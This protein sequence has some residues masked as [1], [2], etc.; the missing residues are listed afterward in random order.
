MIKRPGQKI[1]RQGLIHL[2]VNNGSPTDP[3]HLCDDCKYE[4]DGSCAV[5][6]RKQFAL[7]CES[8]WPEGAIEPVYDTLKAWADIEGV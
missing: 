4:K 7:E 3:L 1:K 8:W 6:K 2:S 5:P